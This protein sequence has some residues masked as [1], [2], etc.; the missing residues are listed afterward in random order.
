M[1]ETVKTL[2]Q[3]LSELP[4]NTTRD[5][6]P[7]DVR[8]VV[9][10]CFPYLG[11]TVPGPDNDRIDTA[12]IGAFFDFGSH[13]FHVSAGDLYYCQDGSPTAATWVKINGGGAATIV[14]GTY[15]IVS[16]FDG[17]NTYTVSYSGSPPFNP[18]IAAG[19]TVWLEQDGVLY[20]D[21]A[22]TVPVTNGSPVGKWIDESTAHNDF[23][24]FFSDAWRPTFVQGAYGLLNA[25]RFAPTNELA[26]T[27]ASLSGLTESTWFLVVNFSSTGNSNTSAL[28]TIGADK[29]VGQQSGG[30]RWLSAWGSGNGYQDHAASLDGLHVIARR[31]LPGS[32]TIADALA[33]WF[34]GSPETL[35]PTGNQPADI[36][37]APAQLFL[38]GIS[39][40]YDMTGDILAVVIYNR[41]LT[42]PEI[43]GVNAYLTNKYLGTSIPTTQFVGT[44]P[45]LTQ[46]GPP[47]APT[48]GITIFAGSGAGAVPSAAGAPAGSYLDATGVWSVPPAGLAVVPAMYAILGGTPL[49]GLAPIGL[50]TPTAGDRLLTWDGGDGKTVGVWIAAAGAWTR[51]TDMPAGSTF[52]GPAYVW[53]ASQDELDGGTAGLF[54]LVPNCGPTIGNPPAWTLGTDVAEIHYVLPASLVGAAPPLSVSAGVTPYNTYLFTISLPSVPYTLVT[55]GYPASDLGGGTL[56]GTVTVP[57]SI[58]SSGYPY[59]DLSGVPASPVDCGSTMQTTTDV[60]TPVVTFTGVNAV[61]GYVAV[62]N[63]GD[64]SAYPIKIQW[65]VTD[66]FG[67]TFSSL[68]TIN[69]SGPKL[70]FWLSGLSGIAG[71]NGQPIIQSVTF[72]I[73]TSTAGEFNTAEFVWL[74]E[75]C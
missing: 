48:I 74:I 23:V 63:L 64:L 37:G 51:A 45:P 18:S 17:I 67:D 5:I 52:T 41:A 14:N 71:W 13:W 75:A 38:G 21:A 46:T 30:P 9:V 32:G 47:W 3:L 60:M 57:A 35:V 65:D 4:D 26:C 34:D 24:R 73:Q 44:T 72:S 40:G 53:A 33:G 56:P 59:S 31:L 15:P 16:T 55:A 8:D 19:L 61:S 69:L 7:V 22:G 43:D 39:G 62:K 66:V 29:P 28:G 36:W 11:G 25:I 10:S 54:T 70:G 50:Y 20:Q 12:G 2:A 1:A 58:V 6:A 68:T 27:I 42:G 49:N